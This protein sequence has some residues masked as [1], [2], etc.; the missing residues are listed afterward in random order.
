MGA[1]LG[2]VKIKRPILVASLGF[3]IGIIWGLYIKLCIVS[4]FIIVYIFIY[5][6]RK[7][8]NIKRY[9]DLLCIKYILIFSLFAITSNIYILFLDYRYTNL[10]RQ[11]NDLKLNAVVIE[12]LLPNDFYEKYIIKIKEGKYKN[13]R[14]ILKIKK[15]EL[16]IK[17]GDYIS[18]SGEFE[19]PSI[20]RNYKGFDYKQYLKTKKIYGTV[21]SDI[22]QIK[23]IKHNQIS[24]VNL[25]ADKVK[26]YI[27]YAS[28]Q[29]FSDEISGLLVG[30]LIGEKENISEKIQEDFKDSSLSHMLAVSGTHV[31]YII[32]GL[33]ILLNNFG[34]RYSSILSILFLI[35]FM[36]ITSF[37]PS[38]VRACI[39]G[40][41]LLGS[42]IFY[43]KSDIYVSMGL[44]MLIIL[45]ENPF[46]ILDIGLILSYGGTI[47]I[48]ILYKLLS[49]KIKTKNKI[50][51]YILNTL[52]ITFSAQ[53]F[54]FPI[55]A[56][57]FNNVSL[58]FF[59]SNLLATPILAIIIIFG[60]LN[61]LIYFIS[62]EI[63]TIL[64]IFLELN[65]KTL[66]FISQSCASIPYANLLIITPKIFYIILYYLIILI[67]IIIYKIIYINEEWKYLSS[68]EKKYVLILKKI[69]I[70]RRKYILKVLLIIIIIT[71]ISIIV[72]NT[73]RETKIYFID[74]GQGDSTLIITENKKNILIDGGGNI[75][76]EIYDI[77]KNTLL[78]YLLDRGVSKIDYLFVSHFDY[79]HVGGLDE[80][81]DQL[82]VKQIIIPKVENIS[83]EEKKFLNKVKE[84]NINVSRVN[85][86]NRIYVDKNTIIQILS[87]LNKLIKDNYINN[88]SL[89]FKFIYNDFSILFTGDIEKIAEKEII[90]NSKIDELKCDV[91]KI[92]HHG[93]KTSTT[94]EFLNYTTPKIALIGVGK[95]NFGHPS[96]VV[97]ERL[98]KRNIKI[99]RTDLNGE[100]MI[101]INDKSKISIESLIK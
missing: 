26:K 4:I 93:S 83:E 72:N 94:E 48:V 69:I 9:F 8:K 96:D 11:I 15:D 41:I 24:R 101:R 35:F 30:I 39:M 37:T 84:K 27:I 49:N 74:V 40:I 51:S 7:N 10:Y 13:T 67:Y 18:V 16:K 73:N 64:S 92:P 63:G 91:L 58:I 28:N 22:N 81:I 61:I 66:I 86:K 44:S 100:I 21:K 20:Q 25:L 85:E 19:E 56:I 43:R 68:L 45:I 53:L 99:Y 75:N 70:S 1:S 62:N 50:I 80:V 59:I 42:R 87:P 60:F 95:N 88:N 82:N 98:K 54:V 29:I 2:V 6:I 36:Y 89:V 76:N 17:L 38:V 57:Y 3:I 34:R 5:I 12:E 23:I 52:L 55:I 77:G 65:L 97:L 33:T 79:D 31:S 71:A 32:I 14:L 90:N 47:G 46:K 78:P